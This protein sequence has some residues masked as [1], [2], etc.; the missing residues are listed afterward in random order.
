MSATTIAVA[1]LKTMNGTS[2][3]VSRDIQ[4]NNTATLEVRKDIKK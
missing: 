2:L 4:S 1:S 3:I